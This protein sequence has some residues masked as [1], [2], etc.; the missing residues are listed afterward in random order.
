MAFIG[1]GTFKI[2]YAYIFVHFF[3][4]F[5][6]II[7][8]VLMRKIITIGIKKKNFMNLVQYLHTILYFKIL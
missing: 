3:L 7:L 5:L 4:S 2:Y 8:R 1:F 6:V